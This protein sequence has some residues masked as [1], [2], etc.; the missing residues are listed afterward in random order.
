MEHSPWEAKS[1]SGSQE[2]PHV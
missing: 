1:R 2:I